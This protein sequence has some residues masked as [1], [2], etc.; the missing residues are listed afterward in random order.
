MK[1]SQL[2]TDEKWFDFVLDEF[3]SDG[4]SLYQQ[5]V[6]KQKMSQFLNCRFKIGVFDDYMDCTKYRTCK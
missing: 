6:K 1:V 2:L 4:N 3:F 5:N